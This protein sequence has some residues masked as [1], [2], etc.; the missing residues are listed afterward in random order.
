MI[1]LNDHFSSKNPF[2]SN[3]QD[4][5]A[6]RELYED[7]NRPKRLKFSFGKSCNFKFYVFAF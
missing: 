4:S 3:F 6:I 7:S 2:K 1:Y 5:K